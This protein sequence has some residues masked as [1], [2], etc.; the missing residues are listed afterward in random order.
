[1]LAFFTDYDMDTDYFYIST[2]FTDYDIL[3]SIADSYEFQQQTKH[4][5]QENMKT[6]DVTKVMC[7]SLQS[8]RIAK[9]QIRNLQNVNVHHNVR[10]KTKTTK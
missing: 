3:T 6:C 1:M 7:Q 4:V 10:Y 8:S 2:D 9:Q 5:K